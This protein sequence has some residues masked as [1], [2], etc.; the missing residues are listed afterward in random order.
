MVHTRLCAGTTALRALR[1]ET[2]P[3][4]SC[5]Y[6][7]PSQVW[8]IPGIRAGHLNDTD[9]LA[10]EQFRAATREYVATRFQPHHFQLNN[11]V[12]MGWSAR[13]S[14]G[15][16]R[17][18]GPESEDILGRPP[19]FS[20]EPRL[21]QCQARP[22]RLCVQGVWGNIFIIFTLG[23]NVQKE[24]WGF[25]RFLAKL[26]QIPRSFQITGLFALPGGNNTKNEQTISKLAVLSM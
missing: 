15:V 13:R 16:R 24:K 1:E 10:S 18:L 12:W 26:Q 11:F 14:A 23:V 7:I 22:R 5:G 8:R 2:G 3:E 25:S 17:L 20:G 9:Y 21:L 4:M 19:R 6:G